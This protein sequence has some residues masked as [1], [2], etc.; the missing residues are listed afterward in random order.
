MARLSNALETETTLQLSGKVNL[1][2]WA[3][4]GLGFLHYNTERAL[5]VLGI[6]GDSHS[7]RQTYRQALAILRKHGGLFI[8]KAIGNM[9]RKSRFLSP[10]LRNTLWEQGYA[11][12]TLETA[13]PWSKLIL[14]ENAIL[15]SLHGSLEAHQEKV[16]AFAHLSHIYRDGAS[17]YV[18]YIFRRSIDPDEALSRWQTMKTAASQTV[19]ACGGTISHQ[20]GVG[21]D[22]AAYLPAEKGPLGMAVLRQVAKTLDPEGLLN[23]GKLFTETMD[24]E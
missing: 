2:S 1:V 18:T 8:G 6:T 3:E 4:R 7:T 12:D 23:P 11:I 21:Q 24:V 15:R 16:L 17:L 22:H 13:L 5:L 19:Q 20:H 14:A 9:W 10:Y